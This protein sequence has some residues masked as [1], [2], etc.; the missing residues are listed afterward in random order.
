MRL[1]LFV[2]NA[3]TATA[4]AIAS[5][6]ALI[7]D[8]PDDFHLEVVDVHQQPE[9]AEHHRI[10]ATPTLIR[11]LPPPVRRLIGDLSRQREVRVALDLAAELPPAPAEPHSPASAS[12]DADDATA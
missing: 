1:T 11:E 6:E 10:L 8:R 3:S 2:G 5:L 12:P 7:G 9:R 4:A